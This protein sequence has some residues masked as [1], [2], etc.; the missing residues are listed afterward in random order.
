MKTFKKSLSLSTVLLMTTSMGSAYADEEQMTQ[1]RTQEQE[2]VRSELNLQIPDSEFAQ[3][4]LREQNR[5]INNNEGPEYE[6]EGDMIQTRTQTRQRSEFNL[7]TPTSDFG[8]SRNREQDMV[9]SEDISQ[10]QNQYQ[11]KHTNKYQHSY[12][13]ESTMNRTM[14]NSAASSQAYAT[15]SKGTGRR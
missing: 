10:N 7:E 12:A 6:H 2:R 13:G 3:A 5:L 11:Y 9:S 1:A 8:Q 4:R 14:Q 15:R